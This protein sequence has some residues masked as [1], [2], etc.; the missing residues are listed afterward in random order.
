[1][2]IAII[3]AGPAGLFLGSALARRGHAVVAV[4]R[5]PGPVGGEPWARRGV[6]QFHHAHAFRQTVSDALTREI[7]EALEGWV[8][9]GAEP[10]DAATVATSAGVGMRSTRE[11]FERALHRAACATPG[12]EVGRGH[13]DSVVVHDGRAAGVVVDGTAYDADLVVDASGRAGRVTRGLGRRAEVGGPCGMAYVDRVYRLRPGA[14]PGPMTNPIAWQGDFDGYLGLVFRHE[15]GKFSVVIAR[16]V[17]DSALRDLRQNSA[18]DAAMSAIPGLDVWTDL[19]R[20]EPVTDVLP[21]G[22]LLDVYRGQVDE[23]GDLVLPGL[24]FIGD[25]VATTT[26]V[27]GRGI[28]T[29]LWQCE[30]LLSL[31]DH[32]DGDLAGLGLALDAWCTDL[33]RPWVEDHILMDGDR[34]ARW[35]GCDV[36][37]EAPLPS[38]LILEAA[39]V[40]PEIMESAGGYLTMAAL[41]ASLRVAEPIAREVYAGGW[42]PAYSPGP[43]RTELAEI[44]AGAVGRTPA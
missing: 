21:G 1:M 6:M 11:L 13:V 30:A 23:D 43:S 42:R 4:D 31:L 38:D 33:M 17:V 41:P 32:D 28:T 27:F 25:S 22:P 29:T 9:A 5:D 19:E 16:G 20:A 39:K 24:V 12:F 34:V 14:E 10:V 44:V 8:D 26:P 15:Q 35:S 37:L 2:R 18:F 7:P 40:R 36:D 3:G